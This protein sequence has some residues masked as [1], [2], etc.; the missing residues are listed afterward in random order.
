MNTY[1][2]EVGEAAVSTV[3]TTLNCAESQRGSKKVL[4]EGD[5]FQAPAAIVWHPHPSS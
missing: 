5:M 2:H 1:I 4:Q 3:Q